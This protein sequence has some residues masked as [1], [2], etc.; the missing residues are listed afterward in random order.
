MCAECMPVLSQA[1]QRCRGVWHH[2]AAAAWHNAG[3]TSQGGAQIGVP[4]GNKSRILCKIG[5]IVGV[6]GERCRDE[7]QHIPA[8][9]IPLLKGGGVKGVHVG[10]TAQRP[11]TCT[12]VEAGTSNISVLLRRMQHGKHT[13]EPC[14]KE[15]TRELSKDPCCKPCIPADVPRHSRVGVGRVL[16][17]PTGAMGDAPQSTIKKRAK[18]C[19]HKGSSSVTIPAKT[20]PNHGA[21]P[22]SF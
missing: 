2:Q 22:P 13:P 15:N 6:S 8:D 12:A 17:Q 7:A 14:N 11:S 1:L 5:V 9:S 16:S 10:S 18:K 19:A 20:R 3:R 21:W 4:Q